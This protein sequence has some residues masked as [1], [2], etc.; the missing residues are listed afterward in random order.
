MVVL[1]VDE[2]HLLW[3][4]ARGYVWGP[5]GQ[6]IA[7]EMTNF[8]QRQTYYGAIDQSNGEVT[9]APSAAGNGEH[10]VAFVQLLRQKYAGK[11]LVLLWD[12]ATYHK[13]AEMQVYLQSVNAGLDSDE[14]QVSCLIFAPN[15]PE[16][17]PMEDI[18]LKAKQYVRK[19]WYKCNIFS[20]VK[21]I[22]LD[23]INNQ[24]FDFSKLH[25]YADL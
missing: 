1:Y 15:A 6:R 12:G 17:N 11:R 7:V 13:G 18:W 14:W 22:F 21:E 20:K 4:D 3:D 24:S 8:R 5:A 23:S 16:Q 9:V 2:C 10:T 19:N 25:M